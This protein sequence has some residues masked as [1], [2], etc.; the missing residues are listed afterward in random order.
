MIEPCH[1]FEGEWELLALGALEAGRGAEMRAHAAGGCARCQDRLGAALGLVGSIGAALEPMNPPAHVEA[2]LQ[3]R[4]RA[5]EAGTTV[6]RGAPAWR[7]AGPSDRLIRPAAVAALVACAVLAWR[8]VDQRREIAAL[9]ARVEQAAAVVPR[10]APRPASPPQ[11]LPA[12]STPAA[13]TEAARA[14]AIER[15]RLAAALAQAEAARASAVTEAARGREELARLEQR[16]ASVARE[17]PNGT[18]PATVPPV[19]VDDRT[20]EVG[21]LANDV[22]RLEAQATREAARARSYAN[23]L[24]VALDPGSRRVALTAVDRSAGRATASA[25]LASDGRLVLT[26]ADLPPL[27]SDKCYQLWI[28]RRDNPAVVSGGVLADASAGAVVHVARV[29]GRADAVTGFAI[30]DEPAGGS[31]SSRGRKLLFGAFR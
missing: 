1:Q 17:V 8:V 14:W 18:P 7:S 5:L 21:R 9:R 26:T 6:S 15:S 31:A 13:S 27:G 10:E 4:L 11:A 25:L 3:Q 22:R 24:Q 23:A 20:E 12:P 30:T 16:L 19:R 2:R 28:I 29:E